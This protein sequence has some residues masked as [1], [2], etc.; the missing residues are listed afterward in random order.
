MK[1]KLVWPYSLLLM[2]VSLLTPINK[3]LLNVPCETLDDRL[4]P[5]NICYDTKYVRTRMY[6]LEVRASLRSVKAYLTF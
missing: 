1:L 5:K 6:T 3:T 4:F 2:D